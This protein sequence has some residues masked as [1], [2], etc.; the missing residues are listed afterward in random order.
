MLFVHIYM[1]EFHDDS[2]FTKVG[3]IPLFPP[4]LHLIPTVGDLWT[5]KLV[6]NILLTL[7]KYV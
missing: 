7:F 5:E 1:V 4:H 3:M 6:Y 2:H